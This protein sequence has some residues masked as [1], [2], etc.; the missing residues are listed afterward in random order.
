MPRKVKEKRKKNQGMVPN[1]MWV[2]EH[3]LGFNIGKVDIASCSS[4][5][6]KRLGRKEL[7]LDSCQT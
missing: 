2:M 4:F 6:F 7:R 3:Q 5:C 1:D